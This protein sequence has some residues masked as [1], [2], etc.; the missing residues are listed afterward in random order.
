MDSLEENSQIQSSMSPLEESNEINRYES[1]FDLKLTQVEGRGEQDKPKP[2][3]ST[4]VEFKTVRSFSEKE[5]VL[6]WNLPLVA[7]QRKMWVFL[8]YISYFY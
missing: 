4:F 5:R 1:P 6:E 3:A 7:L 2:I 8:A